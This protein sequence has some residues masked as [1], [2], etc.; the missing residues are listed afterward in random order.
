M[1]K[2]NTNK[3]NNSSEALARLDIPYSEQLERNVLGMVMRYDGGFELL[4]ELMSGD[5]SFFYLPRHRHIYSALNSLFE[6]GVSID[7][8]LVIEELER[9]QLLSAAGGSDYLAECVLVDGTQANLRDY[10]SRLLELYV[11]R[12]LIRTGER[13]SFE[14]GSGEF[15]SADLMDKAESYIFNLGRFST[16]S[17]YEAVGVVMPSVLELVHI[18]RRNREQGIPRGVATGFAYLDELTGGWQKSN[19]I[20]LAARPGT[21]KT[22]MAINLAFSAATNGRHQSAVA[23]FSLEMRKEELAYRLLSLCSN[24]GLGKIL[25]GNLSD[26]ELSVVESSVRGFSDVPIFFDDDPTLNI[27]SL[28]SKARRLVS[29]E[30][31]ELIMIDYLQLMRGTERFSNREQEVSKISRELK[32]LAKELEVP[33]I[34]LSQLNRNSESRGNGRPMLSDLRESGAIEQDADMVIF[35]SKPDYYQDKQG[36]KES[37]PSMS[38]VEMTI[39]KHRNGQTGEFRLMF[40]GAYQR[41]SVNP[42]DNFGTYAGQNSGFTPAISNN[43]D[44]FPPNNQN[45]S[46]WYNWQDVKSKHDGKD[47]NLPF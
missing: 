3:S 10:I 5:S 34:A 19:L 18:S 45:M 31:V 26:E 12:E 37:S 39:A 46:D 17:P 40:E 1:N 15:S 16:H 13:I 7:F 36:L 28:R 30:R 25:D 23:F 42:A 2:K 29:Q 21:G 47:E 24:I 20:V 11:R 32:I 4:R 38:L 6:S 14:A 27:F 9:M 22:A 35:L 33:I 44:N 43:M 8:L 41:F